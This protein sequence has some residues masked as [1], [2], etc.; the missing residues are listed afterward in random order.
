VSTVEPARSLAESLTRHA[1][2]LVEAAV[3]DLS[4]VRTHVRAEI[5]AVLGALQSPD[6]LDAVYEGRDLVCR[7]GE[8]IALL[9]PY[10]VV[11][12]PLWD[13]MSLCGSGNSVRMRLSQ[14]SKR[15][16]EVLRCVIG[17]VFPERARVDDSPRARFLSEALADPA[18]PVVITYGSEELGRLLLEQTGALA[19]RVVFEG[20]G[21]DPMVVLSGADPEAVAD[22]LRDAKFAFSGQQCTASEL[23]LVEDSTYE[24]VVEAVVEMVGALVVGD[25]D[26]PDVEIGPVG[27][28]HVPERVRE[29]IA[30]ATAKGATVLT[31]G[32]ATG[33]LIRPTL[34]AGVRPD[35]SMWQDETFAPVLGI[36]RVSDG[37][38]AKELIG[39]TRFGLH[40]IVC[41][42]GAMAFAADVVGSPYAEVVAEPTFGRYGTATAE[43]RP[44]SSAADFTQPF[45]G[46]GASGWISERGELK[47][48]PKLLAQEGLAA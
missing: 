42:D 46:Y 2:E 14:R 27:S 20:P 5:D 25:P 1:D 19:K 43:R 39:K 17:E 7:T 33:R 28:D 16:S 36:A 24:A 10:N 40:C 45:G 31:G 48:G 21:K 38:A 13:V 8:W 47:Q 26:D 41:G 12:W 18:V 30:D 23:L 6:R 3:A 37:R 15:V 4:F 34:V 32:D 35:M 22:L 9:Q 29:Q 11:A 44:H